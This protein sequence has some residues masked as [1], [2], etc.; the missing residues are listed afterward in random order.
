MASRT[1]VTLHLYFQGEPSFLQKCVH[2]S[3]PG[4][5]ALCCY[6]T[7]VSSK[8]FHIRK[9]VRNQTLSL[10]R[11][12]FMSMTAKHSISFVTGFHLMLLLLL[13]Q[14]EWLYSLLFPSWAFLNK[15]AGLLNRY[16]LENT[17]NRQK[18]KKPP[19]QKKRKKNLHLAK[20]GISGHICVY[21]QSSTP[22]ALYV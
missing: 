21:L 13:L 6:F 17:L 1:F 15:S 5:I 2:T 9:P 4:V 3:L 8:E 20:Y 19:H 18:K 14:H 12:I 7:Y 22:T 11:L 16:S 10:A